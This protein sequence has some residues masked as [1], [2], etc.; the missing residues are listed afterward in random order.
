[1]ARKQEQAVTDGAARSVQGATGGLYESNVPTATDHVFTVTAWK[2]R[3]V[4]LIPIGSGVYYLF[5]E[6][7]GT[8]VIDITTEAA[9]A[10]SPNIALPDYT[11][12]GMP[13][14]EVVPDYGE[15]KAVYLHVRAK[16]VACGVRVRAN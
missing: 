13:I 9:D 11:P 1:M 15:G 16:D 6:S 12:D 5:S 3:Y 7:S 8:G 14:N 4:K 10:A 2:G